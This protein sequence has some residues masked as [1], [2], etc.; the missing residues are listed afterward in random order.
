M[1]LHASNEPNSENTDGFCTVLY[2]EA[3]ASP[4]EIKNALLQVKNNPSSFLD[5]PLVTDPDDEFFTH[6]ERATP[7]S[8]RAEI[9]RYECCGSC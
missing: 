9:Y 7:V 8:T 3:P 2:F 5:A 4:E 1:L 6:K